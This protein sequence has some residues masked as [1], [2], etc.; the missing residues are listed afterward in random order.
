MPANYLTLQLNFKNGSEIVLPQ[1]SVA[2]VAQVHVH[3]HDPTLVIP[4]AIILLFF[5]FFD[6]VTENILSSKKKKHQDC[7][8][9]NKL[10][11]GL[12]EKVDG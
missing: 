2:N 11:V 8:G 4:S 12:L 7:L 9:Q 3:P 5:S 6:G 1:K 10:L